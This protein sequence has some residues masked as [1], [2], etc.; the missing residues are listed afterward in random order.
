MSHQLST[1]VSFFQL[2]RFSYN[3]SVTTA[4]FEPTIFRTQTGRDT[5]LRYIVFCFCQSTGRRSNPRLWCFKP[6]L[7]RL[8]YQPFL[9]RFLLDCPFA[10]CVF[11]PSVH[12]KTRCSLCEHRV[13]ESL[14]FS[15]SVTK[16]TCLTA[17]YSNLAP[18]HSDC[19]GSIRIEVRGG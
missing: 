11:V 3:T 18:L 5:R 8:S 19:R 6:M 4:G 12:E 17:G 2:Q 9:C 15:P 1:T 14:E 16:A 7:C 13:D 10:C